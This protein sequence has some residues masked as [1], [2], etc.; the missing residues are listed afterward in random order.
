MVGLK[1]VR[2][3]VFINGFYGYLYT[4]RLV[5][6]ILIKAYPILDE[7]FKP[8]K[9]PVPK[10]IHIS[11]LYRV[12]S[13]GDVECI[14]SYAMC[15]SRRRLVKR[16]GPP[17][18]VELNGNYYFYIGL[19]ESLVKSIDVVSALLNY[20]ECFEFIK[21]KICV[22]VRELEVIDA[23]ILGS[24]IANK[25]LS[26]RGV[27][28]VFSSPT[29]LRDPLKTI[30]KQKTLLPTPLVVFA[31]AIYTKLHATG[32]Y[33]KGTFRRELLRIHRLFNETYSTL[34]SVRIKWVYYSDKPVPALTGYVNY[35]VDENY[36]NYLQSH[37]VNVREW[38][39]EIFAY[40]LTLGIGAGRAAGFGHVELKPLQKSSS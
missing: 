37:G 16:T 11:P 15:K 23:H 35:R 31:T 8:S 29:L 4:G 40:T 10:L 20:S 30:R 38:L 27:K 39:R 13:S 3:S 5:K 22:E 6:S 14:Y 25:V 33:K 21:Q 19:Y 1:L 2:V 18:I 9:G 26:S 12:N 28:V 7:H 17:S 36:L 24:E 34:N 32:S